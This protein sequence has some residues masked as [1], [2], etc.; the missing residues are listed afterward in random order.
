MRPSRKNQR[1][2]R[3]EGATRAPIKDQCW[4]YKGE[5]FK[6]KPKEMEIA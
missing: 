2:R 6:E 1:Q 3:V 4:V 5:I